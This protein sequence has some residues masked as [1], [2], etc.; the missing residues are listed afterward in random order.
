MYARR[1]TKDELIKSGITEVTT[2]GRVF[3][4]DREVLPKINKKGY[5]M[6][7]IYV[8]DEDGNNIKV[9]YKSN[10]SRYTYKMR[11]IGLHRLMWAWF[12]GEV[13]E[14]MVVDH[15]NNKHTAQ[16][17]YYLSNLQLLTPRDNINKERAEPTY[18]CR[19][20]RYITEEKINEKLAY[21]TEQ[22][23]QAKKDK[24][25]DRVHKLRSTLA[26]WR[27]KKRQFL[28]NPE[29]YT[30]P[31]QVSLEILETYENAC[32]ARAEKKRQL[33]ANIDS[34][35]KYY[36][37][38]L[39]AYGKDD[40]YVQKLWGEWKLAIAQLHGFKEEVKRAKAM[41]SIS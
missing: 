27:S 17:D 29:K 40:E 35:R 6:H 21:W 36:K 1:L 31:D 41:K 25:A 28:A 32:H 24:D 4:G 22:Y 39:E 38:A 3:K 23:E 8:L 33:K 14:G 30:K 5:L 34:A 10:P 26:A 13:P 18:L 12:H 11:S 2:D 19:M 20:P 37:Q 9:F 15:I 7:S 16:E